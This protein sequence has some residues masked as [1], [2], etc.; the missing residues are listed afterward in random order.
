MGNDPKAS[1]YDVVSCGLAPEVEIVDKYH[2]AVVERCGMRCYIY[3]GAMIDNIIGVSQSGALSPVSMGSV[4]SRSAR[5]PGT[6][7]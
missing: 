4:C 2:D 3:E 1:S 7:S 5:F 6:P